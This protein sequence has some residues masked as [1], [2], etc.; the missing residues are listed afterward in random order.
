MIKPTLACQ[1]KCDFCSAAKYKSSKNLQ[2]FL[3]EIRKINPDD[4]IITGGDPLL[5][6]VLFFHDILA[7]NSSITISITTN[8]WD[9][10]LH[11]KKWI[12]LF[13][14]PRVGVTTSF[15]YGQLRKKPDGTPFSE[16][17]FIKIQQLFLK[18]IGYTPT[19]ISVI[20]NENK[21]LA[22]KHVLLAKRLNTMCK[23]NAMLP[24]GKS[25]DYF[26]RYELLKIYIDII[27]NGLEKYEANTLNRSFGNCPFNINDRCQ[28]FNI[29]IRNINNGFLYN[30]C[31][32]L[33]YMNIGN[34]FDITD[35]ACAKSTLRENCVQC[36]MNR[37]CNGCLLH[38][39]I[40]SKYISKNYCL[41]MNM[42]YSDLKRYNFKI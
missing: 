6:D 41:N 27:K 18:Y 10:Y 23:I 32:D 36:K 13:K 2:S 34:S 22:I 7:I 42:L 5:V 1:F 30:C 35:V 21:H 20:S 24:L 28:K 33:L 12:D 3:T 31:E 16:N 17:D 15:Q 38:N 14:N 39:F 4:V 29:A 19:F 9:F 40:L 11:P 37:I 25:T 26:P 8:L